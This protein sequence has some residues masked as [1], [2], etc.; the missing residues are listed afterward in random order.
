VTEE[1]FG[2]V[3][4]LIVEEHP[5]APFSEPRR[6]LWWEVLKEF[7]GD[8]VRAAT[9]RMLRESPYPPKLA[10]L[11]ERL[12]GNQASEADALY[13]RACEA[14]LQAKA[15]IEDPYRSHHFADGAI[16]EAIR[17]VGGI[18]TIRMLPVDEEKWV[19]RDFIRSY[20]ALRAS[21]RR[22]SPAQVAGLIEHE[23]KGLEVPEIQTPQV[24]RHPE[25]GAISG[26]RAP[27][28]P[29]PKETS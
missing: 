17:M 19:R 29:K 23:N 27:A 8:A 26:P 4:A 6:G 11:I 2:Q 7:P 5:D 28:L 10:H 3:C 22:F 24:V 18:E 12:G 20:T 21:G 9:I 14:W 15:W 13:L 16:P 1:E 25:P